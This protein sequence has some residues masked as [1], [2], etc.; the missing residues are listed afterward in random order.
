MDSLPRRSV[1]PALG[2]VC[3]LGIGLRFWALGFGLPGIYNPDEIPILNR[4]LAFAKGDPNPH[5]FLYPSLQFYALFAWEVA[6]FLV[7]RLLGWFASID[8]FTQE[9]FSD[10]SRLILA[11]RA[12]TAVCGSLTILVV[13]R[14]GSGL[15]GRA[16]GLAAALFMAVAPFAVRDAHYVKLDVPV[17]LLTAVAHAALAT[18]L[19]DPAAAARRSRWFAAGVLGGLA[20][21]TH[22]YVA[23]IVC[24][25]VAVAA[26]DVS[27]SRDVRASLVLL[28][29]AGAGLIA[30]FLAGTPFIVVEPQTAFRDIA[31]VREVDIDRALAG[32]GGPFTSL[33]PY[34][35][36]LALDAM[37]WPVF[38]AAVGGAVAALV[39]DWR[40]GLLLVAFPL[41]F[42]VFIAHTVPMSR[43]VN[44]MLPLMAVAA[45]YGVVRLSD[46]AA[47]SR[48][49][50][51]GIAMVA[52]A[53]P[54]L[55]GSAR[56]DWFFAQ[57]DTR[58]LAR[59]FIEREIPDHASILVQPYS[60][61]I[62]RTRDS[63]VEAL[64]ANLGD[65]A[66]ASTKFQLQLK[67]VPPPP[68]YRVLY[69]GDG[70]T[71]PDKIYV[72]PAEFDHGHDLA[73]L[74][75][76][77]IAYVVLKRTNVPN[78]ELAA[79]E[80]AL[81]Q[82]GELLATF[83]PYRPGVDAARVSPFFHN[84]AARID[85]ALARPGPIVDVWRI[86]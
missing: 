25:Y 32:G 1:L 80:T 16:T 42:L 47:A 33:G 85:P 18:L 60:A 35:R 67:V 50:V 31:G 9:Y 46:W 82:G 13:Y 79:F 56:S 70:G 57:T 17:T 73:P 15:F 11:G 54:G 86:R 62:R 21:S 63:L 5:N 52:A 65:A 36:M 77:Q 14:L 30:G 20:V 2:A 34:L 75:R 26:A 49:A 19:V 76:R 4:A 66:H 43:Y 10:P 38:V 81:A 28:L 27:R 6:F 41:A 68:A 74:R 40:R 8:A 22:Y 83:S 12:F 24:A 59:E 78:D 44:A 84:T 64:T 58:T 37:G 69:L 53:V 45:G 48:P 3:V 39:H 55:A 51:A 7:G 71:D 23:F 72:L 61:P 29:V